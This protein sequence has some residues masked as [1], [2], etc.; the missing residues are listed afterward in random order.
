MNKKTAFALLALST[1]LT[2]CKNDYTPAAEASG[3]DIFKAAC[4]DCHKADQSKPKIYFGLAA[5]NANLA[6]VSDKINNGSLTMP[7][8]PNI[9]G[10]KL[11]AIS[12]FVLDHNAK[13]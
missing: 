3:E 8:F 1:V 2:A 10:D 12:Q 13:K 6:A 11:T 4:A 7:K 5:E 9:T